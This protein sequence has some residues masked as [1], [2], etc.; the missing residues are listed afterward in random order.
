MGG[1]LMLSA[2]GFFVLAFSGAPY[3]V[4]IPASGLVIYALGLAPVVTLATD[5]IVTAAPPERAGAVAAISEMGSEFGGALGIAVLGSLGTFVYRSAMAKA[6]LHGIPTEAA[7]T[8]RDT[9]AGAVAVASQLPDPLGSELLSVARGAFTQALQW[10][11]GVSAVIALATAI[12]SALLL[13]HTGVD[14][15]THRDPDRCNDVV[16]IRTAPGTAPAQIGPVRQAT[17]LTS[18]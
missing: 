16:D 8:I 12:A 2:L 14:M 4:A 15:K 3:G 17:G 6:G 10:T 18:N 11:A 9:F 5:L 7:S 1:G 13:R